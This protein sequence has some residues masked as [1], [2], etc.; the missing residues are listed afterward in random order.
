MVSVKC[1]VGMQCLPAAQGSMAGDIFYAAA[2]R[3]HTLHLQQVIKVS[4]IKLGEA[5]LFGDVDLNKKKGIDCKAKLKAHNWKV[6]SKIPFKI[7]TLASTFLPA[8]MRTMLPSFIKHA[9]ISWGTYLL[10]ARELELSPPQSLD[11]MFLVLGLCAHR[12]D[13]L[14]DVHTGHCALWLS[15]GTTHSSLEPGKKKQDEFKKK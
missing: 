11:D 2:I 10:T 9:S 5:I 8:L 4:S 13:Y 15:K 7:P 14:S 12:H 3:D 1:L 6:S